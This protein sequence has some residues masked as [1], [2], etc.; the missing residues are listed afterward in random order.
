LLDTRV[1]AE[2][3]KSDNSKKNKYY[4]EVNPDEIF[5]ENTENPL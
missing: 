4:H 3:F 1:K 5:D 2:D